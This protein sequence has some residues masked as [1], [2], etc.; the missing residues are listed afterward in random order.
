[1]LCNSCNEQL[2]AT[3]RCLDCMEFLC[4]ACHSAH[5]RVRVT[6]DHHVSLCLF[7]LFKGIHYSTDFNPG[8][9]KTK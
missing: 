6:K 1:M 7:T 9:T 4:Y 8:A 3:A 5:G 2:P